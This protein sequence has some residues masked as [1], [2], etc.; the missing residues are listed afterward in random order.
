MEIKFKKLHKDAIMP[1]FAH[2]KDA[3]ID[4]YAME[5]Y[6]KNKKEIKVRTGLAW[7]PD[8]SGKFALILK[9]KS[10][11]CLLY[12]VLGGVIDHDYR[13]EIVICL[14]KKTKEQR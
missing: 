9:D 10:S 13:G 1:A 8:D 5:D 4:F 14:R 12:N 2:K 6:N 7:E 3:G 11:K